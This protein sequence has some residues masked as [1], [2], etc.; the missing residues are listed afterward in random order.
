MRPISFDQT[1]NTAAAILAFLAFTVVL[2]GL[3]WYLSTV[4]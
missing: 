4:R 3:A 1:K 2:V